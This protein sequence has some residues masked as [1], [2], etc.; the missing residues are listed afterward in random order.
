M[1]YLEEHREVGDGPSKAEML[2]QAHAEYS[3]HAMEDVKLA[4]SLRDM[5]QDLISCHDVELAGSLLPKCDELERMADALT[6]ALERRAQVLK[7]SK[8]MHEQILNVSKRFIV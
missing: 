3:E 8:G 6:G 1:M 2:S 5:G 7:L 4:R